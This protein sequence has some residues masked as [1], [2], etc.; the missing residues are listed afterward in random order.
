[1]DGFASRK[2]HHMA[3]NG[4]KLSL[5]GKVVPAANE[6]AS[7]HKR[8]NFQTRTSAADEISNHRYAD[9]EH[10]SPNESPSV[11]ARMDICL[12]D[13]PVRCKT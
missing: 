11:R 10:D 13:K 5:L 7:T 2:D 6:Q 12:H 9:G 3:P 1:M 4:V 8:A